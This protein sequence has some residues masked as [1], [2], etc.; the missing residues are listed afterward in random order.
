[1]TK[2]E[3]NQIISY[4]SLNVKIIKSIHK[5][6]YCCNDYS[7]KRKQKDILQMLFFIYNTLPSFNYTFDYFVDV[8]N[9]V[10][11]NIRTVNFYINRIGYIVRKLSKLGTYFELT[12]N[13]MIWIKKEYCVT[14]IYKSS[15]DIIPNVKMVYS[16]LVGKKIEIV[17]Q[18]N[19]GANDIQ[20]NFSVSKNA[21]KKYCDEIIDYVKKEI[22]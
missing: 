15:V 10:S 22:N 18:I 3:Y 19:D 2:E 9:N 16:S 4:L 17:L 13:N 7:S 20:I 5:Q 8:Y 12:I 21:T 11:S 1:M 14:D 6:K